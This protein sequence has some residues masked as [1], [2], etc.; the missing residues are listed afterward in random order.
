MHII[1]KQNKT[2]QNKTK[3]L[4][5]YPEYQQWCA[6]SPQKPTNSFTHIFCNLF[7]IKLMIFGLLLKLHWITCK[8]KVLMMSCSPFVLRALDVILTICICL[9][10]RFVIWYSFPDVLF[11]NSSFFFFASFALSSYG[12]LAAALSFISSLHFLFAS[13][14]ASFDSVKKFILDYN[15]SLLPLIILKFLSLLLLFTNVS[16]QMVRQLTIWYLHTFLG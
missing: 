9:L 2:K 4:Y 10:T 1:Q 16:V 11:K 15:H 13:A 7:I 6:T 8:L 12:L 3:I 14:I 5:K